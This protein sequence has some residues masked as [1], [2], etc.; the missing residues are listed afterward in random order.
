VAHPAVRGT[1]VEIFGTGQG[2]VPGA[3]ADG[4]LPT[5]PDPTPFRPTVVI[6]GVSV[7]DPYYQEKNPDGSLVN[8]VYYSGLAPG[9]A[10]V[11]QIDVKIPVA[12]APGNQVPLAVIV[13]SIPSYDYTQYVT[14]IVIQ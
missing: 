2:V 5:G 3:P 11:W 10:G 1:W 13:D 9:F 12:A 14:T 4:D 6:N 7:D 8:H